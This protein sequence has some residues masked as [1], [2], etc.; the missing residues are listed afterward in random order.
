MTSRTLTVS[1]Q[2]LAVANAFQ[3]FDRKQFAISRHRRDKPSHGDDAFSNV[4]SSL[5]AAAV[6]RGRRLAG[7]VF[8][9]VLFAAVFFVAVF[10]AADSPVLPGVS[11]AV[12][13]STAASGCV[14]ATTFFAAAW[15]PRRATPRLG[16]GVSLTSMGCARDSSVRSTNT[17]SSLTF[18]GSVKNGRSSAASARA[19][20]VGSCGTSNSGS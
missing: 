18:G 5:V 6:F 4:H 20:G 7:A 1:S 14:F 2:L 13:I 10:F 16:D 15:R 8:R 17:N 11:A 12:A 3:S 19:S 9:G